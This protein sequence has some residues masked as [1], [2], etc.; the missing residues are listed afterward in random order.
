MAAQGVLLAAT[1]FRP[2]HHAP[3]FRPEASHTP[4]T[5]AA[6]EG[7]LYGSIAPLPG[8]SLFDAVIYFAAAYHVVQ[9]TRLVKMGLFAGA[10]TSF[11]G[12]VVLF[13]AAAAVTPRLLLALQQPF[14][15]VILS[16]YV[17]VPVCYAVLLGAMAGGISRWVAPFAFRKLHIA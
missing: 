9:R 7:V 11:I 8:V 1:V 6:V 13:A 14:I 4:L 16:V 5:M 15:L 10:A 2:G 3:H 12:F 17:L